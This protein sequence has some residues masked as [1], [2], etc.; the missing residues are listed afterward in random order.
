MPGDKDVHAAVGAWPRPIGAFVPFLGP[1]PFAFAMLK[2]D[3]LTVDTMGVR[4]G[5]GEWD[6]AGR[7]LARS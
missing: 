2:D 3:G 7:S 6:S 1:A 5:S 4:Q